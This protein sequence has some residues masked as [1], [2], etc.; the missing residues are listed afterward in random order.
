MGNNEYK[1]QILEKKLSF[2]VKNSN[3]NSSIV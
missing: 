2:K 1:N 3:S